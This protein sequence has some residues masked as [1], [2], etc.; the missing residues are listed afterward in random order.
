ME[1]H[2]LNKWRR[3]V[4]LAGTGRLSHKGKWSMGFF[5]PRHFTTEGSSCE[6]KLIGDSN[7]TCHEK[8]SKKIVTVAV[9]QWRNDKKAY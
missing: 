6:G 9:E 5:R 3:T 4:P 7:F 1:T 2:L 8:E